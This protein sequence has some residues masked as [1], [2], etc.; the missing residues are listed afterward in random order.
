[1]KDIIGFITEIR[2]ILP[3]DRIYTDE[4][5]RLAWGTD[6]GFYRLIPQIVIRS[7]N[8]EEVSTILKLAT[9]HKVP[10][11]FRAGGT[12]LSG[13]SI[14][15]SVLVVA[16]KNWEDY[17]I[18]EDGSQISLQ[19]GII[20]QRVNDLLKPY[21]RKFGPD[22]ASI[23]S[24]MV[25]GIVGNNAS[26]MNCGTHA[27]S[28][29]MMASAR[30]ILTDGT[31]L[32]TGDSKSRAEFE[33]THADM[34]KKIADI[35]D[36]IH[37]NK[38]LYE[39]IRFKYSIKNVT[40]FNLLPFIRFNDPIDII[41][42]LMV[43]SEGSLAFLAEVTMN[44]LP[45]QPY[46]ATAMIYFKTLRQACEAV[47]KLKGLTSIEEQEIKNNPNISEDEDTEVK[48]KNK[49]CEYK[50]RLP[51]LIEISLPVEPDKKKITD[52]HKE[53]KELYNYRINQI[54]ELAEEMF[55][56]FG[57]DLKYNKIYKYAL[58]NERNEEIST[59][60]FMLDSTKLSKSEKPELKLNLNLEN[61]NEEKNDD[62]LNKEDSIN[63]K[64]I[65]EKKE[66]NNEEEKN[67][68]EK[69]NKNML[70]EDDDTNNL[71]SL[72]ENILYYMLSHQLF[73][74]RQY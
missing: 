44:T 8:E 5:R 12:S 72:Q 59:D 19:P 3:K 30:I 53:L 68:S 48:I 31:I 47:V 7:K 28:D 29:R 34:I 70:Y 20:G 60:S 43:G 62:N 9:K 35:R 56:Y 58:N 16:G 57:I 73:L 65:M 23:K 64:E 32:D 24:A 25:G 66:N 42:H 11:T 2:N 21:K 46:K 36:R 74:F 69:S 15:D 14:S 1:M 38:K 41:A 51:N 63:N 49:F 40:G 71:Y 61:E 67:E 17:K 45:D 10:L 37:A 52:F 39:L 18:N 4:L 6:A 55:P 22:P 27:N 33:K 54:G 26:G 13:Q 50:D